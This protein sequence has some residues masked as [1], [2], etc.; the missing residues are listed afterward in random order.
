MDKVTRETLVDYIL[1]YEEGTIDVPRFFALF[2]FI[3]ENRMLNQLQGSYGH[4][5][6]Q[7][8]EDGWLLDNGTY[9]DKTHQEL[10]TFYADTSGK[11]G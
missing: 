8:I 10:E 5:A 11:E 6:Y 1:E 2:S 7:L 9:T 4:T 3:L